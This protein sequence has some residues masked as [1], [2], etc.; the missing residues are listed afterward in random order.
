MTNSD[1]TLPP[2]LSFPPQKKIGK[3]FQNYMFIITLGFIT[4]SYLNEYHEVR[5]GLDILKI[6]DYILDKCIRIL[7]FAP[8][9]LQL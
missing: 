1:V 7:A 9:N 4:R 2:P 3:Q 8:Q 6:Q 5:T